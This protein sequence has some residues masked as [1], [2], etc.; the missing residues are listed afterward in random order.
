MIAS[1]VLRSRLQ[2]EVAPIRYKEKYRVD[3]RERRQYRDLSFGRNGG[4]CDQERDDRC[5]KAETG[6]HEHR[7]PV[8]KISK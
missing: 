6:E 4:C 1:A 8:G 2:I 3:H 7:V 5:Q